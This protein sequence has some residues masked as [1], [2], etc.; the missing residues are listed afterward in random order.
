MPTAEASRRPW[1]LAATILGSSIVFINSST[2]NV[3]LPTFQRQ[4][5]ASVGE[6]Q[7]I[8]N[9]YLLSLSSLMLIGGALGDLLGRRRIYLTGTVL[10]A[11]ASVWCGLAPNVEQLIVA[12]IV[13]GI[14]GAMLTPGSL[15][16][17]NATFPKADRGRAIGLWSGFT[18][19]TSALGPVVGGYIIDAF[20]WRWIFFILLPFAVLVIVLSL[21]WV[22]ESRNASANRR[23]DWLGALLVALGLGGLIY[24]LIEA[25]ELGFAHPEVIAALSIGSLL[26]ALFLWWERK[27]DHPMLPLELFHSTTFSGANGL[28]F[29]LYAALG[30][31]LFFLPLNLQQVQGYSATA[32]GAA[33]LPFVLLLSVLSSWA[34]GLV[35]KIGSKI[36]LTVGPIL[37][38]GGFLLMARPGIGGTYWETF[39]PALVVLGLG[40]SVSVAPLTATVMGSAPDELSGTASGVNNAVSRVANLFAVAVFGLIMVQVF[41]TVLPERFRG[42]DLPASA[43]QAMLESRTDLAEISIP[44]SLSQSQRERAQ[45]LIHRSFVYSYRRV[46]YLCAMIALLSALIAWLTI[47]DRIVRSG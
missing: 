44:Q 1:I 43:Q 45:F 16:I 41:S 11:L 6:I 42:S 24:G 31:A 5:G 40:M 10:F 39:F 18:A 20:T 47:D 22:P 23:I 26:T 2:V 37:T 12:R 36:P 3:A 32:T 8:I 9:G 27:T 33:F 15:A 30:A 14:G 25:N 34:G 4:L 7:W 13:Q 17:I 21:W 28:T 38:A 19:L 46:M 35:N 29:A